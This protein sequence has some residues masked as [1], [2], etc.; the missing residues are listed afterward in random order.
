MTARACE[1]IVRE[2]A[3]VFGDDIQDRQLERSTYS[4][5]VQGLKQWCR[6]AHAAYQ[7]QWWQRVRIADAWRLPYTI[8]QRC[9]KSCRTMHARLCPDIAYNCNNQRS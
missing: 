1:P 5:S 7:R 8:S 3:V 6:K 4:L 2:I 9:L